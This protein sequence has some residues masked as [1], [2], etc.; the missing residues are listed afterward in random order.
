VTVHRFPTSLPSNE[1]VARA[2]DH[3]APL[4]R[5]AS[6]ELLDGTNCIIAAQDAAQLAEA[7]STTFLILERYSRGFAALRDQTL[8]WWPSPRTE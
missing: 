8:L 1:Q 3:V 5:Q 4:A 2:K 6:H 7:I